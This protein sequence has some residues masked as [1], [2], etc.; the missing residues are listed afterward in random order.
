MNTRNYLATRRHSTTQAAH[1]RAFLYTLIGLIAIC[2]LALAVSRAYA[3][4]SQDEPKTYKPETVTPAAQ[5]APVTVPVTV[6]VKRDEPKPAKPSPYQPN[7]SQADKL[8]IAQLEAIN[9]QQAWSI[10]SQKLPE[11]QAF[12]QAV[13]A[14]G[15]VCLKIE[16]EN[17][18]PDD[19]KC[20][21][22]HNPIVFVKSPVPVQAPTPAK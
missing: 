20:D 16:K 14:I 22:N 17:K 5:A 18:W 9:A 3:W 2:I 10:A 12:N 8:K 1:D 6:P 21:I 4:P 13:N 11:Y 19:V 7:E 15:N